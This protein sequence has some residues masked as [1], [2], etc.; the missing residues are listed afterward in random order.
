MT[1]VGTTIKNT[2][3]F[4]ELLYS[5]KTFENSL[6][7]S[8]KKQNGVYLTNTLSIID[9]ILSII[10]FSTIEHKKIL[11]PAC[12]Q[13]IFVLRILSKVHEFNSEKAFMDK[14]I[15]Q[16]LIFNDV[17]A[18]MV[19]YTKAAVSN[20]YFFLFDT[21]YKGNFQGYVSD[22][23][24]RNNQNKT[25]LFSTDSTIILDK[26]YEKVDYVVG[27]P[28]Y[29]SLYGRRDQKQNE[30]QRIDYLQNY[31]QFPTHVQNG[32]INLVML[33]LEHSLDFLKPNGKMSFIIDVAFFETAYQ[34][35]RQFL[36]KNTRI[37]TLITDI[38]D[39]DV[40]SGQL[41]IQVS[42]NQ[43]NESNT[44]KI[45]DGKTNKTYFINQSAWQNPKDEFKFRFNGCRVSQQI[46]DT[47]EAKKDKTILELYPNKNLRT[48][49]M[50][51]DME[52][53]FTGQ[54]EGK[55]TKN[56][57]I[58][59]YF[60]GSKSLTEKYGVLKFEKYFIYD[61][62]LQDE[63]N[64]ALKIELEKQGIKNKKRI[65]LGEP[66]IYNNP[67]V[68]I[69]QSAKEII[70]TLDFGESAANNS[71][72]VF[73]L[74]DNSE[75]TLFILKFLCGWLNSDLMTFYAQQTTIIRFSQGKQP[76]IKISDL[77]TIPFPS[78]LSLQQKIVELV[79]K[80]TENNTEIDACKKEINQ[81]IFDYYAIKDNEIKHLLDSIKVF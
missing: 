50:M 39:F 22:F 55:N 21:Q 1:D 48:C 51:L 76:Q 68:Y 44:V 17:D 13:G 56:M 41:I 71:L 15:S 35:T 6:A 32:K 81:L 43:D 66:I 78:S 73:S 54:F 70:A 38:K 45:Q 4:N 60:Q 47:I 7:L 53:K 34:Y 75:K 31:N 14:F 28:P 25:D 3:F 57:P 52:N 24:L 18:Q 61:K 79:D 80:I 9:D 77:G 19:E 5:Q 8:V 12:G 58:Y 37:E 62:P 65:G 2:S 26:F 72:Y 11:E 74:R 67:K 16:N 40:V 42:K 59:P 63:I 10:D 64:D 27:N 33:F 36:L 49:T 29:V 20:F 30:Q 69:R 23:T 46:I